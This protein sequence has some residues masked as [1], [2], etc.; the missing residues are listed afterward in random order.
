MFFAFWFALCSLRWPRI[1]MLR[2]NH[3]PLSCRAVTRRL[4]AFPLD[5]TP[6]VSAW[7][8]SKSSDCS[9]RLIFKSTNCTSVTPL[10]SKLYWLPI[11]QRIEYKVSSICYSV[12]LGTAHTYISDLPE[13]YQP[14][15]SSRSAAV[16]RTFRLPMMKKKSR[17]LREF[18]PV[19]PCTRN[20][21]PY[22][23]RHS[24]FTPSE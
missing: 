21:L 3:W 10:L 1:V 5:S 18:S 4:L 8:S 7:L 11:A 15:R 22:S 13:L 14:S 9:T 24:P 20:K 23:L 19:G 12:V 16:S 2:E 6:S 17:G